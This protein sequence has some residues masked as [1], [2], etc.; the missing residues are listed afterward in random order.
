MLKVLWK[1]L[2]CVSV[3][4][5]LGWLMKKLLLLKVL[6]G[7]IGER[8]GGQ[9]KVLKLLKDFLCMQ[10]LEKLKCRLSLLFSEVLRLDCIVVCFSLLFWEIVFFLQQFV[11][12]K[13]LVCLFL[14]FRFRLV[15]SM[16]FCCWVR[17]GQFV[18]ILRGLVLVGFFLVV[19]KKVFWARL[20]YFFVFRYFI[21]LIRLENLVFILFEIC[22]LF[23]LFCLV[24][25]R[26]IL[27]VVLALQMVVVEVFF[28]IVMD[29]MFFGWMNISGLICWLREVLKGVLA[30]LVFE[31]LQSGML[32]SIKRGCLEVM[33][34]FLC[35]GG[36]ELLLWMWI[37]IGR[38]GLFVF[39]FICMLVICFFSILLKFLMGCCGSSLLFFICLQLF[40]RF[41]CFCLFVQAVIMILLISCIFGFRMML[42]WEWL[43]M[44][45]VLGC[46]FV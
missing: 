32:F 46:I 21:L 12:R 36:R 19:L 35:I 26:I 1:N 20:I 8:L 5:G 25:M 44:A 31:I 24:V 2:F 34:L 42:R 23:V 33:I 17:A 6:F 13:Y 9:V 41:F 27:L 39:S 28:S 11:E 14:L 16:E 10:L 40:M 30:V 4:M 29:L 43:F 37:C 22:V 3:V 18:L 7:L 15:L 45:M 38:L